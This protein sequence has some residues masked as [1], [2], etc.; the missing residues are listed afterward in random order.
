[1]WFGFD[2]VYLSHDHVPFLTSHFSTVKLH[3]RMG[4]IPYIPLIKTPHYIFLG[5]K[6]ADK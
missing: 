5:A 1:M 3:E 4:S 6:A 2:N